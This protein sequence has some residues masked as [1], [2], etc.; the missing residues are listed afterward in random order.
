MRSKEIGEEF[1]LGK[2]Q[3][4]NLWLKARLRAEYEHFQGK[5]FK[6]IQRANPQKYKIIN[7]IHYSWYKKC[8]SSGN[9]VNGLILKEEALKIKSSLDQPEIEGFKASEGLLEKWKLTYDIT[10]KKISRDPLDVSE[11]KVE[12]RME[13]FRG[14]GYY[15]KNIWN[16]GVS[17]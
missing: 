8:Q 11:I 10:Y 3:A 12:P 9:C 17:G 6:D 7:H 2:K 5:G 16:M 4:I 1:K 14:R 15:F 13:R